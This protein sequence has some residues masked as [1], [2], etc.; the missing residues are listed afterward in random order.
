MFVPSF[1]GCRLIV[2]LS[3]L[4]VPALMPLAA[5]TVEAQSAYQQ[6]NLVSDIPGLAANTDANLKNPWGVSF[7]GGSPFWV[8]D[9]VTG[10][11]T[12]YNTSGTPL[13]LIVTIPGGN[14][15][16]QVFNSTAADFVLPVGGK[17]AFIFDTLGGA[18]A[19]WN[20]GSGTT[21][22]TVV[23]KAGTV[24]TGLAL[25]NSAAG[26]VLYAA[27]ARNNHIDVYNNTFTPITLAGSFTD[28]ALPATFATY[29]IQNLS[30][31]LY[32]TYESRTLGGGVLDAYDLNGNFLRR[33]ASNPIGGTL[34]DPWGLTIAPSAFGIFSNDLLVGNKGDGHISAFDPVTGAFQGQLLDVFSN[35]ITNTG[36]WALNFGNGGNGGDPKKLYFAAG[37][38]GET[39]G[40]FGSIQ[41]VPEP[42][43]VALLS[44]MAVTGSLFALRRLRRRKK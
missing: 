14:P 36:L 27:D 15:T 24:Y 18:I 4:L 21:A 29:N 16:G 44:G 17:S 3:V 22:Q 33:I 39:D 11:A 13:G 5:S 41:A 32:V 19:G 34:S 20:G 25:G 2:G 6:I 10:K 30:G 8:S 40:L 43:I 31:T 1:R 37:I 7:S 9:Q 28:A 23:T 42:G 12:L 26:N 38:N 35:P